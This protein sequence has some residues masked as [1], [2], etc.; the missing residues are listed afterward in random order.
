MKKLLLL[1]FAVL[2]LNGLSAQILDPVSWSFDKVQLDNGEYQLNFKAQ[3]EEGWVIYSQFIEEGGPVATSFNFDSMDGIELIDQQP[4]EIGDYKKEGFDPFFEMNLVKYGKEV[5]FQQNIR[6]ESAT[7]PI[8][9]HLRFMTCNDESCL[10]PKDVDFAFNAAPST[11]IGTTKGGNTP[12]GI[13]IAGFLGGLLALLTP[14][15]F[16]MIPLTVSFF[17]KQSKTRAKGIANALIYALSIIVIYV[18][19]GFLVTILF[20]PAILHSLSTNPWVNLGFFV[21]FIL[22]AFSFFGF[23]ELRLPNWLINQSDQ[24][25]DKGGLLG[26]FFMAFTLSLVSFSCTGPIIGTLLVEAAIGGSVIGPV[27]GMGG[28]AVALALPFAVFAA[29]PGWLNSLPRSGGW[30][31]TVKVLLGFLEVGLA[32]KF[33]SNAD[34]VQQ[35]GLLKRETFLAI[36]FITAVL[37]GI[38]LLGKIKFPHDSPLKKLSYSRIG[39]AVACFAFAA[40][41]VPGMFCQ[42]LNLVSGFPPP[43]TYSYQCGNQG[44]HCPHGLACEHSYEEALEI[45]KREKKPLLLDFTGWACANCRRMEETV[46]NQSGVLERLQ[47]DYVIASLYVDENLPLPYS[48]HFEYEDSKGNTVKVDEVG[49]KWQHFEE[50]CFNKNTQPYYVLMDADEQLLKADGRGFTSKEDFQAFLESG[51]KNFENGVIEGEMKCREKVGMK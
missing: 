31:N 51:L 40:Y 32:F 38:Y 8:L 29:F 27:L 33:L 30:L 49:Q 36:W 6:L 14:C 35:W 22:F 26:I 50:S 13:F 5:V 45:A 4:R 44:S 2:P 20:G 9:G 42:P 21:V 28:F 46:W 17:T 3:M 19:L 23:Y 34:L 37:M 41:L 24:A 43:I 48:D 7:T 16:P 15:V 1:L 18:G 25:S 10:P 39:T 12:W 11:G 47:N